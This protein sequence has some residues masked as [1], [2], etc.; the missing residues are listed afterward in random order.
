MEW[1]NKPSSLLQ[2]RHMQELFEE[3]ERQ[4]RKRRKKELKKLLK[5]AKEEGVE[6]HINIDL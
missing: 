2:A 3:A 1:I 4:E 6:L 5:M